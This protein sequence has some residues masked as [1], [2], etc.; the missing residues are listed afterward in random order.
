VHEIEDL[1]TPQAEAKHLELR[2]E[3]ADDLPRVVRGDPTRI[4][5][6]ITNLLSNA[7]KFTARGQVE[8]AVSCVTRDDDQCTL[9]Y[10]VRD[11]GIGISPEIQARLFTPFTQADVSTT[12]QF[13][14]TGL[15]LSIVRRLAQLLGGD[16]G[17]QS[18][19]GEGSEFWATIGHGLDASQLLEEVPGALHQLEVV[20]AEDDPDQRAALVMMARALGWRAE[21]VSSGD[22]LIARVTERLALGQP[23]DAMVV[24]WRIPGVDGLAALGALAARFGRNRIPAAV[25]ASAHDTAAIRRTPDAGLA[26]VILTKPIT[27]SM[28]FDAVNTSVVRRGGRA[29]M[30]KPAQPV[31]SLADIRVLVVDDSELNLEVARRILE[32]AGAKVTLGMN[33]REAVELLRADPRAVDV[34]LMD[35]QMPVMDGNAAT[36]AIRD[37]LGLRALPIIALTAGALLA[38]RQRSF[39]AGMT[40]FLSKPLDPPMLLRTVARHVSRTRGGSV[41]LPPPGLPAA[42]PPATW[43]DVAGIDAADVASRLNHDVDLF[44]TLLSYLLYEF[45]DLRAAP[46]EHSAPG[47]AARLHKLRGSAGTLGARELRRIAG[48]AERL[49]KRDPAAPELPRLLRELGEAMTALVAAAQPFLAAKRDAP[50][51]PSA[52]GTGVGGELDRAAVRELYEL[53]RQQDFAAID[54][55]QALSA[56]L[57]A[58]CPAP[59]FADLR[60][61]VDRFDFGRA[62]EVISRSGLDA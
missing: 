40:D 54:R 28:L 51:A 60:D 32:T 3:L 55:F 47:L 16:V 5:Q 23:P 38:E 7:I 48:D 1:M 21:A 33:G 30:V 41:T 39:D 11:T 31:A 6:I 58:A 46:P 10:A 20:I 50:V 61:A 2:L 35:V 24:D 15:G 12:R 4:R 18:A 37:E 9:R 8:L 45:E 34:V 22:R 62:A 14:G 53:L 49:V 13:G 59:E 43:P 29:G 57:R 56:P 36:A 19:P 17:V 44:A 26:D 52:A 42:P 27:S 25:L